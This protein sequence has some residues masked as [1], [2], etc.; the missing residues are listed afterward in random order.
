MRAAVERRK[1]RKS[2]IIQDVWMIVISLLAV[3][4]ILLSQG[5]AGRAE[6]KAARAQ[7]EAVRQ[8]EGRAVAIDFLCGGL[9]G[10]EAAGK[11]ALR[12]ELA[13]QHGQGL[14][15]AAIREYNATISR[16]IILQARVSPRGILDKRTG[17]IDCDALSQAARATHP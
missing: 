12:G 1:R 6:V 4:S 3:G 2:D 9:S 13:G 10:V 11:K 7:D 15:N 8:R 5:K 16:R 14:P 17:R